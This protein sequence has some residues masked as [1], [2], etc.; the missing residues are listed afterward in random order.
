MS[1]SLDVSRPLLQPKQ[2]ENAVDDIGTRS[3]TLALHS[4]CVPCLENWTMSQQE[5]TLTPQLSTFTMQRTRVGEFGQE[6]KN[7][8][9]Q[10]FI[11]IVPLGH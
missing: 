4:Q 5:R 11:L 10:E 9:S 7:G 6:N 2:W 3:E 1:C 8:P